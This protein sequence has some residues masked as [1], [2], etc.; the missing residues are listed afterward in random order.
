MKLE[1]ISGA[2]IHRLGVDS[3]THMQLYKISGTPH[4]ISK[5]ENLVKEFLQEVN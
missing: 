3:Y 2:K 4:Q 5:A 1:N